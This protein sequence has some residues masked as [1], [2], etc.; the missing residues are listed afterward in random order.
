MRDI[1]II[2][3]FPHN[4]VRKWEKATELKVQTEL[5]L[6]RYKDKIED[7]QSKFKETIKKYDCPLLTNFIQITTNPFILKDIQKYIENFDS[8]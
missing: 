5:A 8:A 7:L 3:R 2:H 6:N 4:H 1:S